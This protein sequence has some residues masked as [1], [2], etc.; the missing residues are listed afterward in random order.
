M[1]EVRPCWWSAHM[2]R[3]LACSTLE[4]SEGAK[5]ERFAMTMRRATL[6]YFFSAEQASRLVLMAPPSARVECILALWSCITDL[7]RLDY[8]Q[9]L[10]PG[11]PAESPSQT[12][13]MH[14]GA[15]EE[16]GD[17]DDDGDG[18]GD[19][20]SAFDELYHRLGPAN[21]FNPYAPDGDYHLRLDKPDERAVAAMIVEL[22]TS[23]PGENLQDET[24][25]G[26]PFEVGQKWVDE[27]PPTVGTFV[28]RYKTD[29]GCA[30]LPTRIGLA[31]R[32]LM[33]GHGR[34]R[35]I[36]SDKVI[37]DHLHCA[38]EFEVNWE[39]SGMMVDVDGSLQPS[40]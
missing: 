21:M 14:R 35:C 40:S 11:P 7:E 34:W 5:A 24:Y 38:E 8:R 2:H 4:E 28:V 3:R 32:L 36:P 1:V 10:S 19:T 26:V 13:G 15:E 27:G 6:N 30:S 22:C 17:E 16:G 37:A 18:D 12:L 39:D 20:P 33:P 25:N 9:L 31:N 23:E 29:D